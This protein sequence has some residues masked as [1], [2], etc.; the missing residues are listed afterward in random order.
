MNNSY[1]KRSA[2]I[3][4]LIFAFCSLAEA[5][6]SA[7]KAYKM[8]VTIPARAYLQAMT[9]PSSN[10]QNQ[11]MLVAMEKGVRDN[12]VVMIRTAVAK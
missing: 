10:T 8:S 7:S 9:E 5:S 6:P 3:L 12:Q 4:L 11:E 1:L 2:S